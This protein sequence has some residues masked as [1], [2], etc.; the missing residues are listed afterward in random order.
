M[1]NVSLLEIIEATPTPTS[2]PTVTTTSS[3]VAT[4]NATS[5]TAVRIA[6]SAT[7]SSE[8][9]IVRDDTVVKVV[10]VSFGKVCNKSDL[11]NHFNGRFVLS[12]FENRHF[13]V[14]VLILW[15]L[16]KMIGILTRKQYSV[17]HTLTR[18][19]MY[20]IYI[21]YENLSIFF[22]FTLSNL[23]VIV[24]HCATKTFQLKLFSKRN[25]HL[26]FK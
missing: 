11:R 14:S 12:L 6:W 4:P 5:I 20:M 24:I 25:C 22:T 13:K 3:P 16:K 17:I 18:L 1:S 23:V 9:T 26:A 19:I 10:D 8:V 15:I 7:A 2:P 21:G